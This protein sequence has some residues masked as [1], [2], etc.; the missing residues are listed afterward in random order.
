MNL[1]THKIKLPPC[2]A[3]MKYSV[4]KLAIGLCIVAVFC[5]IV[6][7]IT[8]AAGINIDID[9]GDGV[10]AELELLVLFAVLALAPSFLLLT[11]CFARII[12]VFSFVRTAMGLQQTPP[13]QILVSVALFLT[14]FIMQPTIQEVNQVAIQPLTNGEI[15]QAEAWEYGQIPLKKFMIK[16]M[17][18][19]DLNMFLSISGQPVSI[20][21][22]DD[23]LNLGFEIIIPAF[24]T[25]ELKLAFT[26]GFMLYLPFLVVDMVVASTLMSMGMVMLPPSTISM[27]FKLMLFIV[28]DGWSL[29]MEMLISGFYT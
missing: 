14:L 29:I 6:T 3:K 28:V 9:T 25:S 24:I 10:M 13:N 17:K 20:E 4:A 1:I 12:M 18:S 15:T 19:D 27:P 2:L 16:E 5:F 8:Y 11:T 22:Q 23:L 21:T 7:P 26:I